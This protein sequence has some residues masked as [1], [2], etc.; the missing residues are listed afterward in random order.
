MREREGT[1]HSRHLGPKAGLT[2]EERGGG[3][4]WDPKV[5]VPKLAGPD[6]PPNGHFGLRVGGVQGAPPVVVGYSNV[7]LP[8]GGVLLWGRESAH[9]CSSI[10]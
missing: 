2:L 7:K 10:M 1:W 9:H 4:V 5:C 6:F 3:E 8:K